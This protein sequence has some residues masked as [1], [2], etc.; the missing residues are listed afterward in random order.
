MSTSRCAREAADRRNGGHRLQ[1][2]SHVRNGKHTSLKNR[3]SGFIFAH[4]KIEICFLLTRRVDAVLLALS[5]AVCTLVD[6]CKLAIEP[7]INRSPPHHRNDARRRQ[8][9]SPANNGK[10]TSQSCFRMLRAASKRGRETFRTANAERKF[11]LDVAA[12]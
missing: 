11:F 1:A 5:L 6:I 2:E 3:T 8:V 12:N 7:T 9:C 10:Q 4:P